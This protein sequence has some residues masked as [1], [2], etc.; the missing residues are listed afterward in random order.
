[1][2]LE[3][4]DNEIARDF[5]LWRKYADPMGFDTEETFNAMTLESRLE[6]LRGLHAAADGEAVT[7]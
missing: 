3:Y 2:K 5:A 1:M 7:E 6:V 4:T